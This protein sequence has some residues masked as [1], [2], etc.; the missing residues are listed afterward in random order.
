MDDVKLT[1]PQKLAMARLT[2][3]WTSSYSLGIGRNTLDALVRKGLVERYAGT[4]SL[5]SPSIAIK[6]RRAQ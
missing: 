6:Y 3:Q 1:E 2:K 5:F 4:G